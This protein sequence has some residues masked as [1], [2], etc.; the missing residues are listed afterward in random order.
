MIRP[1]KIGFLGSQYAGCSSLLELDQVSTGGSGGSSGGSAGAADA[2]DSGYA[3]QGSGGV[4]RRYRPAS[5][6]V[7]AISLSAPAQAEP[8]AQQHALVNWHGPAGCADGSAVEREAERLL[9]GVETASP[10]EVEARVQRLTSG[11]YQLLLQTTDRLESRR[12]HRELTAESCEALIKPAAIIVALAID[13]EAAA[14]ALRPPDAQAVEPTAESSTP[15]EDRK[16]APDGTSRAAEPA[17]PTRVRETAMPPAS[18]PE[19]PQQDRRPIAVRATKPSSAPIVP[20]VRA[21]GV[22]AVGALPGAAAGGQAAVGISGKKWRADLGLLYLPERTAVV[23]AA[24]EK[25]GRIDMIAATASGCFLPIQERLELG[26]CA[27][28]EAGALGGEGIG[29]SRP[30]SGSMGWL[31]G[32]GGG[33]AGYRIQSRLALELHAAAVA[34][35]GRSEFVLDELGSVHTPSPFGGRFDFGVRFSFQ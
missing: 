1:S 34:R 20:F 27:G 14:R 5:F 22:V 2:G 3:S 17:N 21:A 13:P 30:R 28:L 12:F 25:G 4:L 19:P 24:P 8:L 9:S 33:T 32:W 11:R 7:L 23:Q 31:A 6:A 26:P 29:V 16:Q 18:T 15:L 35:I 10:L